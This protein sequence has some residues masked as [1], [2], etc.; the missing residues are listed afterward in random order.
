MHD[1]RC[2]FLQGYKH[3]FGFMSTK[4]FAKLY[5]CT[6]DNVQQSVS[7]F[8]VIENLSHQ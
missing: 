8:A 2:L 6:I 4:C 5:T 1:I 7:D 3:P